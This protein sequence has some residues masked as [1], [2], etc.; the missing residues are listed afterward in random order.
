[1][2]FKDARCKPLFGAFFEEL[3]GLSESFWSVRSSYLQFLGQE[4]PERVR[5]VDE[6]I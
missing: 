1:M 3:M 6:H 5:R 4:F 2:R